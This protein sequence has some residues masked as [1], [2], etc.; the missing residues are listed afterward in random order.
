M[1]KRKCTK[2]KSEPEVSEVVKAKKSR[3]TEVPANSECRIILF[4]ITAFE[5]QAEYLKPADFNSITAESSLTRAMKSQ[6]R[7]FEADV[8]PKQYRLIY[9]RYVIYYYKRK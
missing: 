7:D 4:A 6:L 1:A 2:L 8:R 9:N 3:Q 5:W